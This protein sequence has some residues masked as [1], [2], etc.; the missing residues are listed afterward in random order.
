MGAMMIFVSP[1]V[2]SLVQDLMLLELCALC[3]NGRCVLDYS[4]VEIKRVVKKTFKHSRLIS[5]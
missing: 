1:E 4:L 3:T 5:I 2:Y